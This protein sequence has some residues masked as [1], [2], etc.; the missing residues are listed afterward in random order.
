MRI[1]KLKLSNLNSLKG[2]YEINFERPPFSET[3]LFAITGETGSG[4]TTILDAITLAIYHDIARGS[5]ENDIMSYGTATAYSEVEFEADNKKYRTSWS[6]KR[7]RK[8]PEGNMQAAECRL[9]NITNSEKEEY[10]AEGKREVAEKILKITKGLDKDKFLKSVMLAQGNFAAFL[11]ANRNER[12]ALLE[13]ITGQKDYSQISIAAYN[14]YKE[15]KQKLDLLKAKI[16]NEDLLSPE[17]KEALKIECNNLEEEQNKLNKKQKRTEDILRWFQNIKEKKIKVE[18][19]KKDILLAEKDI[20]ENKDIE[21]KILRH[22]KTRNFQKELIELQSS[23]S[24]N[25]EFKNEKTNLLQ[26]QELLEKTFSHAKKEKQK[27][28]TFLNNK[29]TEFEKKEP[30]FQKADE[31]DIK[32]QETR[33]V[34]EDKESE[35]TKLQNEYQKQKNELREVIKNLSETTTEFSNIG[36]WLEENKNRQKISEIIGKVSVQSKELLEDQQKLKN[37]KNNIQQEEKRQIKINEQINENKDKIKSKTQLITTLED[38]LNNKQEEQKYILKNKNQ[39][40]LEEEKDILNNKVNIWNELLQLA[41]EIFSSKKE[42]NNKSKKLNENISLQEKLRIEIDKLVKNREESEKQ[43]TL[44]EEKKEIELK[45][46]KYEDDRK[47]LVKGKPCVLCGAT[48]HPYASESPKI[49]ISENEQK[50]Q[51]FKKR[52]HDIITSINSLT[53][54]KPNQELIIDLQE[55]I[56]GYK[57]KIN[58]LTERFEKSRIKVSNDADILNTP[59]EIKKESEKTATNLQTVK[60]NL[61]KLSEIK[62]QI[63]EIENKIALY[64][65]DQ[66]KINTELKVDKEKISH[67]EKQ[68][69]N[70]REEKA[71]KKNE[72]NESVQQLEE[73]VQDFGLKVTKNSDFQSIEEKLKKFITEY[74]SKQKHHTE[75]SKEKA[76]LTQTKSGLE[77]ECYKYEKELFPEKEKI[78]KDLNEKWSKQV[79]ERQKLFDGKKTKLIKEEYRKSIQEAEAHLLELNKQYEKSKEKLNS[80][81]ER[82]QYIN[83]ELEKL[84]KQIKM[85]TKKVLEAAY[86]DFNKIEEIEAARLKEEVYQ[87]LSNKLQQLKEN[88]STAK[89]TFNTYEKEL[90]LEQEKKLTK[91]SQEKTEEIHR[92]EMEELKSYNDKLNETK[93][94]IQTDQR[95]R[96]QNVQV[97][98]QIEA[99]ELELERWSRLNDLIG[100]ANGDKF[101]R[102]A[103]SITLR[104]L[105]EQANKH[106]Q[107]LNKRYRVVLS[108]EKGI[109]ELE[110]DIIDTFQADNIRPM[111]TL[112]GGE[113]FLVSLALAL[114]LSDMAS[115]NNPV[116]SLFIDEGFGTL[117]PETLDTALCALDNLQASG[118]TIGIISHVEQLKERIPCQIQVVKESG[119]F[120]K[121]N[122]IM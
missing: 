48:E 91:E 11:N 3:G 57:N 78:F 109:E 41:R 84:D 28:E 51:D 119:G 86:P 101:R 19:T 69:A 44:W 81:K 61:Q 58:T 83:K 87:S 32:I 53:E 5:S 117:D 21:Q 106:L 6:K 62:L 97:T 82:S 47:K 100:S 85:L 96:A 122:A 94:K 2:E 79:N 76:S 89:T 18:E 111:N 65:E 33:A 64:K 1:L 46:S 7:A 12:G 112:S 120:S 43:L 59:E 50:I 103:Q 24:K 30:D 88:L 9:A 102:F 31:L 66:T 60:E 70:F 39:S 74:E 110:L 20:E 80:N 99:R 75:L 34:L 26:E 118:K 68:L 37:L 42:L 38:K 27:K 115:K 17:Q 95:I 116:K 10:I 71:A 14:K 29:K 35:L 98:K 52:I 23:K 72:L 104:F 54:K 113:S 45:L 8:N 13:K 63:E 4:K 67:I 16:N 25:T 36:K 40:R 77:K 114:G 55:D 49:T 15:E 108:E 56:K 73:M 90:K 92:Q 22:D 93:V 105:A 107:L 121:I